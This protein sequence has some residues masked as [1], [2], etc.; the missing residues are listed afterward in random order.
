MRISCVVCCDPPPPIIAASGAEGERVAREA[1]A[2]QVACSFPG[3][4]E[5]RRF[6]TTKR[7]GE[8]ATHA[9]KTYCSQLPSPIHLQSIHLLQALAHPLMWLV[10]PQILH[11]APRCSE[12]PAC[13]LMRCPPSRVPVVGVPSSMMPQGGPQN[14]PTACPF[15][16]AVR[17]PISPR[18]RRCRATIGW[19]RPLPSSQL[20]SS[21]AAFRLPRSSV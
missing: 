18:R 17:L 10:V 1:G 11:C 12:A 16:R 14:S 20:R 5:L 6:L 3:L 2:S 9:A 19:V 8:T 4:G 15:A 13:R 21:L 7:H